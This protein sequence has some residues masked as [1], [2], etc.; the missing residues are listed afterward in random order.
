MELLPNFFRLQVS[1]LSAMQNCESAAMSL[2]F[3]LFRPGTG[4]VSIAY[5]AIRH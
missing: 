3:L 1:A 2:T 4:A 5:T